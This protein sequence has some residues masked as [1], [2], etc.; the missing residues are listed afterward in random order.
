MAD[1]DDV[2]DLVGDEPCRLQRLVPHA[3]AEGRR[4]L[5][6]VR[7]VREVRY[8]GDPRIFELL[9]APTGNPFVVNVYD[10]RY[11]DLDPDFGA[12][13]GYVVVPFGTGDNPHDQFQAVIVDSHGRTLAAGFRTDGSPSGDDRDFALVRLLAGVL[14]SGFG[15][16]GT[17]SP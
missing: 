8:A 4:L 9:T 2:V 16:S 5:A 11:G 1:D 6:A 10:D 17:P 14:S 13:A 15:P 7:N 12:G 3:L